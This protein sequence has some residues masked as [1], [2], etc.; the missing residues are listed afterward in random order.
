MS[1]VSIPKLSVE[2]YLAADSDAELHSE[3]HDGEIFPIVAVTFKHGRIAVK[4]ARHL[5]ER[6]DGKPCRVVNSPVRVRVSP[7]RFV[8]P[9]I[10]V[11]CGKPAYTDEKQE[12]LTNPKVIIEILSPSTEGYDRGPKFALYRNLPSFDEYLLIA[13]DQPR[14]EVFRKA[15]DNQ[16]ILTIWEGLGATARVESLDITLPLAEIYF[17]VEP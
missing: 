6:L 8:Y 12:T 4:T 15:A 5:D 14:I 2:E 11:V 9:D 10:L 1:A 13:Q 7:T 17:E 3:Y 16:W